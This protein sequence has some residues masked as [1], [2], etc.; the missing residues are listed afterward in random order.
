ML[1]NW[2]IF[3]ILGF[4]ILLMNNLKPMLLEINSAP[5]LR[6]D[7]EVEVS[8]GVMECFPSPK[9]EEVKLPLIRD[10][11]LLVAPQKKVKYLERC[12]FL[13]ILLL[14]VCLCWYFSNMCQFVNCV[15][16]CGMLCPLG[17]KKCHV[18]GYLGWKFFFLIFFFSKLIDHVL[19]KGHIPQI[20]L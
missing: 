2:F 18:Y 7:S 8:I 19:E 4:D 15:L 13:S 1:T 9:D 16:F 14:V 11:L 20:L 10:T 6:I 12:V 3:Q 17:L 5:S